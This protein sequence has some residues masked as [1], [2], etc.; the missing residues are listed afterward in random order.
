MERAD[1][2]VLVEGQNHAGVLE[3]LSATLL[4]QKAS[5]RPLATSPR[6][7]RTASTA[8]SSSARDFEPA[9]PERPSGLSRWPPAVR[10]RFKREAPSSGAPDVLLVEWC[11]PQCASSRARARRST[12]STSKTCVPRQSGDAILAFGLDL[13]ARCAGNAALTASGVRWSR[14]T[15]SGRRPPTWRASS[16]RPASRGSTPAARRRASMAAP[17]YCTRPCNLPGGK[18][19]CGHPERVARQDVNRASAPR[20]TLAS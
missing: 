2:K 11:R 17:C 19:G 13:V 6:P 3:S 16:S 1:I 15:S 4:G 12:A 14:S 5:D 7:S 8:R 18:D 20:V 10:S 9:V